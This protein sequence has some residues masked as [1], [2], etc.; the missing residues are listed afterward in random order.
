MSDLT[1]KYAVVT[2]GGKGIGEAIAAKLIEDGAAGVAILDRDADAL[3]KTAETLDPSGNVVLAVPCDV[4]AEEQVEDAVKTVLATFPTIDILVNNAGV[5]RDSMFHKMS[6]EAWDTVIGVNLYGTYHMCKHIVPI[7]RERGYGRIV[8]IASIS[9]EGNIGQANYSASKGAVIGFTKTLA[10]ECGPKNITANCIAPGFIR[11]DM[12]NAV[13]EDI[14]AQH[15]RR[16]PLKRLGTPED[17]AGAAAF[18]AGD[19]ASFISG[20]CLTV[21]GGGSI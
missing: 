10:L 4:S 18:L 14:V 5:A 13:T 12:Y 15:V 16:I 6:K 9:A 17:V 19:D 2:G 7:M 3:R 20:Q 11:T 8:N 1:G 21:S